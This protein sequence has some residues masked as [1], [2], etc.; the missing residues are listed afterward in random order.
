MWA[1]YSTTCCGGLLLVQGV[2]NLGG[3]GNVSPI[4]TIYPSV[5]TAA[6]EIPEPARRYLQQAFETLNAPDAAAVMAGS[7]VDAMLKDHGLIEGNVYSR[8]EQAVE[9]NILT[10]AMGKWAHQVRLEAN[11]PRHADAED[12][13]V[14]PE[15]AQQ[16]VEFA[17][18]LGHFL[19]VLSSRINKG[20]EAAKKA[21][22]AP[23][24]AA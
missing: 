18:A 5:R 13:H 16:S 9:K 11:R 20:I 23:G 6:V 22:A 3:L 8:I 12:P 1:V 14:S 15:Q 21:H 7:A 19:F 2:A 10:P 17:D 4:E 24:G